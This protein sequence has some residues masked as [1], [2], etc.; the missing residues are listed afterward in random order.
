[1]PAK[2]RGAHVHSPSLRCAGTARH[3]AEVGRERLWA[4]SALFHEPDEALCLNERMDAWQWVIAAAVALSV[5]AIVC[6]MM[7]RRPGASNPA[8]LTPGSGTAPTESS[9]TPKALTPEHGIGAAPSPPSAD[10][11]RRADELT[12]NKAESIAAPWATTDFAN[13]GRRVILE[14]VRV[15]VCSDPIRSEAE[16]VGPLGRAQ[17]EGRP[18]VVVTPEIDD[19]ACRMLIMNH[20]T[21]TAAALCVLADE[22]DLTRIAERVGITEH[23]TV[24]DRQADY[25][26]AEHWGEANLWVSNK[27]HTWIG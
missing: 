11:Q 15:L 21:G 12:A 1:M 25:C 20:R 17:R 2:S 3:N 14:D 23:S 4:R 7:L 16:L 22:P 19:Q 9:G 24:T 5:G 26:P 18:L 13:D 6:V 10:G 27:R 8:S